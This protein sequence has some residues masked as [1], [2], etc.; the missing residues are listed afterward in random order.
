L[1]SGHVEA[2]VGIGASHAC[3]TSLAFKPSPGS[4]DAHAESIKATKKR[5]T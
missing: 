5:G 1:A 2:S 4:T 3:G